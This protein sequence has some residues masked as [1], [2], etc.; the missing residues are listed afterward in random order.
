[1]KK[2]NKK[3]FL[4]A[5][6]VSLVLLVVA[7]AATLLFDYYNNTIKFDALGL[8]LGHAIGFV[9]LFCIIYRY[10]AKD[11]IDD[12]DNIDHNIY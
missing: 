7:V 1:M 5:L 3:A 2:F 11:S 4:V 12:P 10:E 8:V 6:V 9:L